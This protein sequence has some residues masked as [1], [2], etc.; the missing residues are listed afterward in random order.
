MM[1]AFIDPGKERCA[2]AFSENGKLV[3]LYWGRPHLYTGGGVDFVL[4]EKP[5]IYR[6]SKA[7][8]NDLVDVSIALGIM[9]RA[10]SPTKFDLI[11]PHAWKG[12]VKKAVFTNR[13][14]DKMNEDEKAL[15]LKAAVRKKDEHNLIDAIGLHL[16][17]E[18]RIG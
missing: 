16:Y 2:V 12:S 17:H 8:P 11:R 14:Q 5:Q 15:L 4:G 9:I 10:L 13:I 1:R 18:R 7:D 3:A 6:F